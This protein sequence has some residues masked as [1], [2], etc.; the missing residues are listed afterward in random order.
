KPGKKQKIVHEL[1]SLL[2]NFLYLALFF[3]VLRTYTHLILLERQIS[4]VAYGLTLIKALALAKI[5]LTGETLRLG[6][7]FHDKP[8]IVP[9]LYATLIFSA[10]TLA[11]EVI[12][13]VVLG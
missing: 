5:I 3:L 13:H 2:W 11:F 8:L 1:Q 9:T 12:E 7:R 6:E 4:Y 10:L